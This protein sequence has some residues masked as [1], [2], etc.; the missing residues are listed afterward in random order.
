[1]KH[2]LLPK[3]GR[4][5]K[6]NLHCH[7]TVSDGEWNPE[8]LKAVYLSQGYSIIAFTDHHVLV[9]HPE[10]KDESFLPLNGAEIELHTP[11][12]PNGFKKKHRVHLCLIAKEE[13][14][15]EVPIVDPALK[16]A[17]DWDP[18]VLND[19]VQKAKA[20]GHFVTYNHPDWSFEDVGGLMQYRGLDALEIYNSSCVMQ[21]YSDN[22]PA[23]YNSLARRGFRMY[24]VAA[25]DNH[26][27]VEFG[28]P[29]DP[30]CNGWVQ[31]KAEKLEYRTITKALEEGQFYAS[32]GPEIHELWVED[33]QLHLHCSPADHIIVT[34]V[35]GKCLTAYAETE[36]LTNATFILDAA[37]GGAQVTVY[38]KNGK[39][40]ATRFYYPEEW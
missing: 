15:L 8:K 24:P 4:F 13:S 7:S 10:L 36:P 18:E 28:S 14:L 11:P 32:T 1:M 23:V 16:D 37:R 27:H 30:T 29:L 19:Y 6:A 9:P 34:H 12:A 40:A 26:N 2:F 38:D 35:G 31:I 22:S 17:R 5:Y 3:N 33:G 39:F 21:G 25:D 20:M